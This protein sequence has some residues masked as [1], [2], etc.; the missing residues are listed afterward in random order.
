VAGL[1]LALRRRSAETTTGIAAIAV[2]TVGLAV[3]QAGALSGPVLLYLLTASVGVVAVATRRL[4]AADRHR[5][6]L[7]LSGIVVL[8]GVLAFRRD[9]GHDLFMSLTVAGIA[10]GGIFALSGIGLVVTYRATGIFNLSHGAIAMFVAYVLW[11]TDVQ[12]GWPVALAAPFTLFVVGPGIGVLLERYVFRS[13]EVRGASTAD[14]LVTT[15]GVLVLLIGAATFIWTSQTRTNPTRLFPDEPVRIGFLGDGVVIGSDQLLI[16]VTSLVLTVLLVA[17]FRYTPLGTRIRAVVDRRELA[18]LTGVNANRISALSWAV[19]AGLAGL[20]GV[21]LAPTTFGLD[22]VRLTL[23][24]IETF[25]VAVVA[26]LVSIPL[27]VGGGLALGL[28]NAYSVRIEFA[29]MSEALGLSPALAEDVGAFLDPILPYVSV[30]LLFGA[31]LAFS[32]LGGSSDSEVGFL[33][34]ANGT[35]PGSPRARWI[36]N[37][38]I[39]VALVLLPFTIG[40]RTFNEAHQMLALAI[41]FLSIVAVTGFAGHI[42]LGQAAFAGFGGFATARLVNGTFLGL[43]DMPVVV[44]MLIAALSCIPLGLAAGYPALRRRG[45]FLALTTLAIGLVMERFVFQN[46]FFVGQSATTQVESPVLFGLD[47]DTNRSFYFFELLLL[48]G[49][50]FLTHRLRSGRLGRILSAMRDSDTATTAIGINLRRYKLFVF[51]A[52]AFLAGIGGSLI[53]QRAGTFDGLSFLTLNGLF[54]FAVVVVAGV[55][56]IYGALL[57]AFIFTLLGTFL[58]NEGAVLLVVGV[59]AVLMGRL[60]GGLVGLAQR[61]VMRDWLAV[62]DRVAD[63]AVPAEPSQTTNRLEP[64]GPVEPSPLARRLLADVDG[65]G[66]QA[67]STPRPTRSASAGRAP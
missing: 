65:D 9:I 8:A 10:L 49:A 31:L 66:H 63:A 2:A 4:Q 33:A 54:W 50:I 5:A 38:V 18:E 17:L 22:P 11:Q 7:A 62:A 37:G 51:S 32:S 46:F 36:I 48:A 52:S 1:T 57:G 47:L 30:F 67:P 35:R 14:K 58:G 26:R 55:T 20:T 28:L 41:V 13:L 24:V 25:A 53:T 44:A 42:T 45:L 16:I 40:G 15:V 59:A 34:H 19:G 3:Y 6:V 27:A 43:P 21:L 39:G 61:L 23:L 12:W 56:S 64:T 29:R 60:P